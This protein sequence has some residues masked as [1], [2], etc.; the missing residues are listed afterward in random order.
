MKAEEAKVIAEFLV[1]TFE[2]EMPATHAVMTALT[3]DGY[4]YR[5]DPTSK[6]ALGLARHIALEDEWLL[7]AVVDG[8]FGPGK[9]E[10]DACGLMTAADAAAFHKKAVEAKLAQIRALSGDDLLRTVDMFGAFQMPALQFLSLAIRHSVHHRGQLSAYLRAAGG[11]VPS[12][13]GP[14][15]DTAMAAAQ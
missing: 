8:K 3:A 5:P 12:I 14:S 1:R 11:K 15:A 4:G 10:S 13:Y 6:T 9:D 2:A 7:E